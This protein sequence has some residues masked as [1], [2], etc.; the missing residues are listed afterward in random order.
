MN[1]N[2]RFFFVGLSVLCFALLSA[3]GG[4][5]S[6]STP[7]PAG[8]AEGLWQ[9]TTSTNEPISGVVLDTGEFWV[10][11]YDL[12]GL[13]G[14]VHGTSTSRGGSFT[15]T[16]AVDLWSNGAEFAATISGSYVQHQTLNGTLTDFSLPSVTFTS[17]FSPDYF[18]AP[19][20]AKLTGAYKNCAGTTPCGTTMT[21]SDLGIITET[22]TDS[23]GKVFPGNTGTVVPHKSGNVYDFTFTN[24]S[25]STLIVGCTPITTVFQG[26]GY[27]D[28][29]HT[30][31]IATID[32]TFAF[33]SFVF[34]GTKP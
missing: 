3:C 32:T 11:Y 12:N 10:L 19:S 18:T 28:G 26:I 1:K 8:T 4:G 5:G 6:S 7:P 13:P 2:V 25:C 31:W 15:S 14:F 9:G 34:S 23:K 27:F 16:D 30:L 21:I 24:I 17:T 22:V 33:S 20:L 29:V